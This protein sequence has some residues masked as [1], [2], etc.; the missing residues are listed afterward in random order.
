MTTLHILS[1]LALAFCL[2]TPLALA[3]VPM[4]A[5]ARD[6][7]DIVVRA[8]KDGETITIDV[9]MSVQAPLSAVWDVFTDYDHMAEFVANVNSSR[10]TD[11]NGNTLVVAQKS[12]TAFGLLKFSF[13][14]VR[15]VELVPHKEIRSTLISGDMKES[16]FTTRLVGEAGGVTRVFNHG[17]FIPTMW[18]PPVIGTVFLESETRRQFAQLRDEI[19]RRGTAP[20][21][22]S[23][24]AQ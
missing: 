10:I 12:S 18:V 20:K 21:A 1:A 3:Q 17:V 19:M 16:A 24:S 22:A 2:A 14:N 8:Q 9:A 13:D 11:R 7:S 6:D 4:P 23:P 15:K 5:D